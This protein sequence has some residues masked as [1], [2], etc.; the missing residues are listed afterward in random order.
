[1]RRTFHVAILL[2]TTC[3]VSCEEDDFLNCYPGCQCH[4]NN[5]IGGWE[6]G[7]DSAIV[8]GKDTVG[9]FEISVDEW[10]NTINNDVHL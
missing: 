5:E 10:G 9:G 4:N 7:N 1:M 8:N 6:N 3:L 2:L